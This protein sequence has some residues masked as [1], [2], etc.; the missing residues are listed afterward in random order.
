MPPRLR[1]TLRC[2]RLPAVL[3]AAALPLYGVT[4]V[5]GGTPARAAEPGPAH[6]SATGRGEQ[7][8]DAPGNASPAH[9]PQGH[10]AAD[11]PSPDHPA[12]GR[13]AADHPAQGHPAADHPAPG[14]GPREE[15]HPD[16]GRPGHDRPDRGPSAPAG[17]PRPDAPA[18]I[19]L[20]SDSASASVRPYHSL[21][22]S[23]PTRAGSRAGEGRMRP[24]RPDRSEAEPE[25]EDDDDTASV[26]PAAQPAEPEI[27]DVPAAS[28]PPDGA[29]LGSATAPPRSRQATGR[30]EAATEP[31]LRIL[32]LGSG[33]VLIGLGLGLGLLGLRL[34]RT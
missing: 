15:G 17:L 33:L 6:A 28:Q 16:H 20:P 12:Q 11:H 21:A 8:R 3:A 24:G 31:V 1:L 10:P 25:A 13:P 9:S 19:P 27:T 4:V 5:Y 34:R 2:L 18:L 7:R 14:H 23:E 22:W 29:G 32:P 26:T 30:S